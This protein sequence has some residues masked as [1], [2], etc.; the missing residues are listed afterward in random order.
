M[1][2]DFYNVRQLH[3]LEPYWNFSRIAQ[4]LGRAVRY[5]SHKALPEDQRNVNAYIYIATHPNEGE[6]VDQYI[7]KLAHNKSMII[8]DFE[9][10]LKESAVDCQ[11]FK[12]MNHIGHLKCEQ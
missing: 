6:T 4:I 11:L 10:A 5:C 12:N 7:A 8:Q 9:N 1:Q 2:T 3:I